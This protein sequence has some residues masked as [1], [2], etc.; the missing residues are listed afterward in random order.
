MTIEQIYTENHQ[1]VF[2]YV[3]SVVK[4][5][6]DAEEVTNDI[7][8]KM[9]RLKSAVYSEKHE[10]ALTSWIRTITNHQILDF[11]RTN[12]QDRYQAVSD[13]ADG[14][15]ENLTYF[16]FV[17]PENS[18]ADKKILDAEFH[19]R[20]A[21]AFRTLKPKYR[22][23]AILFFLR[24]LPYAEIAEI[25]NVPI[26]TVKGMIN[27][28]RAMLQHELKGQHELKVNVQNTEA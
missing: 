12:H 9:F 15:N 27:R 25:V 13:F 22:K 19:S 24:D 14:Q 23:I 20:I 16:S 4:N 17:A 10:T 8:L 21:K 11:F 7:F 6:H 26:G 3:L 18:R 1:S 28:S 2:N 5:Y